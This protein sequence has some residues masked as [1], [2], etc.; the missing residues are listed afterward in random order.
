MHACPW[1]LR[2]FRPPTT[3]ASVAERAGVVNIVT[4]IVATR[5]YLG[6]F[7]LSDH[8]LSMWQPPQQKAGQ[9]CCD[10]GSDNQEC[11]IRQSDVE[12]HHLRRCSAMTMKIINATSAPESAVTNQPIRR[13][14]PCINSACGRKFQNT[15]VS[16]RG[17]V[18]VARQL[19]V[20][21]QGRE[22]RV[23][24][25]GSLA[26]SHTIRGGGFNQQRK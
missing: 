16:G 20:T 26:G 21:G 17:R 2:Y 15:V 8:G 18:R 6:N 22:E 1:R 5:E 12:K 25:Q 9:S 13:F 11:L 7:L 10:N 3:S 4:I 23:G 24:D 19:S 14:L